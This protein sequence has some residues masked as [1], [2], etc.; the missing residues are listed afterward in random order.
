[1]PR[2]AQ[3][4]YY[5]TQIAEHTESTSCGDLKTHLQGTNSQLARTLLGLQQELSQWL[6]DADSSLKQ[7]QQHLVAQQTHK[8]RKCA[9]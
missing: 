2:C 3:R 6:V 9:T 7:A 5:A 1:M 4:I 8:S